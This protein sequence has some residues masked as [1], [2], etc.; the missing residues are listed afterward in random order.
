[1]FAIESSTKE[2]ESA[3]FHFFEEPEKNFFVLTKTFSMM[4]ESFKML[5]HQIWGQKEDTSSFYE[6]INRQ[7]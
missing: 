6:I 1:M 4:T 2:R 7:R 3:L 5:M